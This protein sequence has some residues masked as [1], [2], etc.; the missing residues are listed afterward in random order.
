[1]A[2]MLLSKEVEQRLG[3]LFGPA[4]FHYDKS[5]F[6]S[7]PEPVKEVLEFYSEIISSSCASHV[8]RHS[9]SALTRPVQFSI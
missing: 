7:I 9:K 4:D 1:M 5:I 2:L 8:K 6:R 3:K